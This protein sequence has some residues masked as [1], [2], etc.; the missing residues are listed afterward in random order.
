[1]D[2]ISGAL[3][4]TVLVIFATRRNVTLWELW[5]GGG[6]AQRSGSVRGL[7][8]C[9]LFHPFLSSTSTPKQ[10]TW[11]FHRPPRYLVLWRPSL[12]PDFP[13]MSIGGSWSSV[14]ATHAY[15]MSQCHKPTAMDGTMG[16]PLW[17]DPGHRPRRIIFFLWL[18]LWRNI[19]FK[20]IEREGLALYL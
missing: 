2:S 15:S 14:P 10:V 12:W 16:R 9:T 17:E 7:A 18:I 1:M 5:G 13:Y 8:T 11:V 3:L 6:Y 20:K 19:F 4:K